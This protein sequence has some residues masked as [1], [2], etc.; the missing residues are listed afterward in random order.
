MTIRSKLFLPL[1]VLL[2]LSFVPSRALGQ[3]VESNL[4][5]NTSA[6]SPAH[7][8]PN[9]VDGWGLS[10][11]PTS[12]FWVSDQNTSVATLYKADGTPIPVVGEL[13]FCFGVTM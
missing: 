8:D 10:F 6:L 1:L 2:F 9:L 7:V 5:A 3:Y 13:L 11:F 4:D 12:P